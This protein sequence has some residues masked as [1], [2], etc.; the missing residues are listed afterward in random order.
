LQHRKFPLGS[1]VRHLRRYRHILAVL[2]KYGFEEVVDALSK[3]LVARLG[4][5]VMPRRVR[6]EHDGRSRAVRTRL[7]LQ[8]L[9]PTFIKLGQMLSTRPDLIPTSYVEEL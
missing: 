4:A 1:T 5:R 6:R 7:A 3:R 8:E 2:M 9:G